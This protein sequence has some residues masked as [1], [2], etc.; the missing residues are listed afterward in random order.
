MHP[1]Q[2]PAVKQEILNSDVGLIKPLT[3]KILRSYEPRTIARG[4]KRLDAL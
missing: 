4:I 3:R 2:L 1:A